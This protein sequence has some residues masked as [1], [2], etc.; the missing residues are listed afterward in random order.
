MLVH[1]GR[2]RSAVCWKQKAPNIPWQEEVGSQPTEIRVHS[3]T[4]G[5]TDIAHIVVGK[6][7]WS[8]QSK[9]FSRERNYLNAKLYP[10]KLLETC[11]EV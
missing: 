11:K 7:A 2:K 1:K 5:I 10:K 3:S 8:E 9:W 4:A 6:E